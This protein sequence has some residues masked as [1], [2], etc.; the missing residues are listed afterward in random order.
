MVV[1]V[2]E[3][4]ATLFVDGV[5]KKTYTVST[6]KVGTGTEM[7][8]GRTPLGRLRVAE[9]FGEGMEP[10][11]VFVDRIPTGEVWTPGMVVDEERDMILTRILWLEGAEP[12]NANT[13]DR[14]IYLHGTRKEA[15]LGT[16]LSK[17]CVNFS[18]ADIVE[19]FDLMP[20]G[21]EVEI[22]A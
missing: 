12:D 15:Q 19:V 21:S 3:Q 17:G 2:S 4:K 18:N 8:S 20:V 13:K 1:K 7:E 16:P 14:Y 6:S 5:E 9:K 22:V 10:G 11:T